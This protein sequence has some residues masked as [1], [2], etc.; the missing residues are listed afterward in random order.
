MRRLRLVVSLCAAALV[1]SGCV[2]RAE[3]QLIQ[4]KHAESAVLAK[5]VKAADASV[6]PTDAQKDA[7][8]QATAQD[9]EN[10]DRLHN[11]WQPQP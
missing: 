3:K 5:R 9:W 7:F 4:Q 1:C 11:G 6:R 8:I 2:G 10:L